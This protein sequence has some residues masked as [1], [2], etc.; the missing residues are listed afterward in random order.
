MVGPSQP[1]AAQHAPNCRTTRDPRVTPP[2]TVETLGAALFALAVVH[3]FST[4][5]FEHLAH[6]QPRHAGLW[7]S[8]R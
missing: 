2:T 8:A 6:T 4:K 1:A 3:T 5:L 7:H